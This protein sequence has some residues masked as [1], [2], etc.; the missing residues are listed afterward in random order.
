MMMIEY[1]TMIKLDITTTITSCTC[2][3]SPPP[4]EPP[5]SPTQHHHRLAGAEEFGTAGHC[6][7]QQPHQHDQALL[8]LS[9]HT[10]T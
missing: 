1:G 3:T 6:A 7:K 5:A 9:A 8:G 10:T 4:R 2:K